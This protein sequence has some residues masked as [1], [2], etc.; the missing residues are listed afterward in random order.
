VTDQPAEQYADT[1]R[2]ETI[3]Y[4]ADVNAAT[5]FRDAINSHTL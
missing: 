1:T 3:L 2:N 5:G 4:P